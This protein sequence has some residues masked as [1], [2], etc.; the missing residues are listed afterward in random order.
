MPSF[1]PRRLTIADR[2]TPAEP[3]DTAGI[4][5]GWKVHA[6]IQ[7]W[8]R[9]VDA[10]ASIALVATAG[11]GLFAGKEVFGADGSLHASHGGQ[12][13]AVRIM[14]LGF[15]IAGAFALWAVVPNLKRKRTKELAHA[16]LVYFGH[17]RTRSE[18]DIEAALSTLTRQEVLRQLA[19][20]IHATSD[21]AWKKH[22]RLQGALG[23]LAI[24]V[25]AFAVAEACF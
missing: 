13:W 1:W 10:K 23:C 16:G 7:D 14:A 8:T 12:L 9:G 17:L 4:E 20:Q 21:V 2:V 19:S 5:F 22:V 24:A 15:L 18:R 3:P 11:I 25:A 6:A